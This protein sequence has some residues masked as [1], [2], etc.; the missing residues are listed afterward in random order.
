MFKIFAQRIPLLV[1][2]PLESVA[3]ALACALSSFQS[4]ADATAEMPLVAWSH[5]CESWRTGE[6]LIVWL[7]GQQASACLPSLPHV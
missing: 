1:V 3:S 2:F 4:I 7:L 6:G 5:V